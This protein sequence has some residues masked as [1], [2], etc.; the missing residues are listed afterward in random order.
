MQHRVIAGKQLLLGPA[1]VGEHGAELLVRD[2]GLVVEDRA[3][4]DDEHLLLGHRLRRPERETLL[5]QLVLDHVIL[6]IQHAHA[7]REG[8]YTEAGDQL[9]RRL[10]DHD[11]LPAALLREFL[12]DAA[13]QGRF[14]RRG[15][16]GENDAR[17]LLAHG[18]RLSFCLV[19]S[20][21]HAFFRFTSAVFPP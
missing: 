15:A 10:G 6:E 9:G 16:A 11:D 3:V 2:I 13:D 18:S 21:Y 4:V 7:A 17:D 14:A 1:E 5:V 19:L 20:V 8:P 12:E